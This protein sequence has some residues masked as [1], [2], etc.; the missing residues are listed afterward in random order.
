MRWNACIYNIYALS[1]VE[2]I[3]PFYIWYSNTNHKKTKYMCELWGDIL[4][5]NNLAIMGSNSSNHFHS[6]VVVNSS[7]SSLCFELRAQLCITDSQS[8]LLFL[9]WFRCGEVRSKEVFESWSHS[10]LANGCNI[11]K[12]F[13]RCFK[14][15]LSNKF[16]CFWEPLERLNSFLDLWD[17]S[18]RL[19]V[20][21]FHEKEVALGWLV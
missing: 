11:F 3:N 15:V 18:T 1:S 13:L 6:G 8:K 20:V 9:W 21:L 4:T 10:G 19:I 12:C 17:T 7:N 5:A 16:S 2:T 14:S